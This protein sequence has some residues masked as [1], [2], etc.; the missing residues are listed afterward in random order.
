MKADTLTPTVAYVRT[1]TRIGGLEVT[2]TRDPD[3]T[4]RGVEI[5]C[6]DGGSLSDPGVRTATRAGDQL[7]LPTP[8]YVRALAEC[9]SLE[10]LEPS[11]G[12]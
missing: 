3:G 5:T 12:G 6:T 4:L 9:L 7:L 2:V 11:D 10:T 8:A 1:V